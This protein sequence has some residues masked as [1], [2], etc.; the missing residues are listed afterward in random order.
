MAGVAAAAQPAAA[1]NAPQDD[2]QLARIRKA[3]DRPAQLRITPREPTFRVEVRQHPYF[4]DQPF[5]WTFDGG[6]VPMAAPQFSAT[7]TPPIVQVDA[8]PLITRAR[9]ALAQRAAEREVRRAMAD[10]C[11]SHSCD[12]R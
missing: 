7:G 8:L 11:A 10:Y 2:A 1:Q 3:L 12:P 9:K 5:V 6:G 4:T